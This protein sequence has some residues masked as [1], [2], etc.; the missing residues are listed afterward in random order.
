MRAA[1][2]VLLLLSVTSGCG[3]SVSSSTTPPPTRCGNG[4]AAN[5]ARCSGSSLT[6]CQIN[7]NAVSEKVVVCGGSTPACV[8]NTTDA[9]IPGACCP[10]GVTD[11][12]APSCAQ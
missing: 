2:Q 6:A 11:P 7:G 8:V 3:L 10:A 12:S 4:M 1:L 5:T 9:G